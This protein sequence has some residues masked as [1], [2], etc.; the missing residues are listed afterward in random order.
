MSGFQI[1]RHLDAEH[2]ISSESRTERRRRRRRSRPIEGLIR[3]VR[4]R[5][6]CLGCAAGAGAAVGCGGLSSVVAIR[7]PVSRNSADLLFGLDGDYPEL[8]VAAQAHA[9][10]GRATEPARGRLDVEARRLRRL[11]TVVDCIT[12]MTEQGEQLLDV[13]DGIV[14]GRFNSDRI[15][16]ATEARHP[17]GFPNAS[18]NFVPVNQRQVIPAIGL[19]AAAL[20]TV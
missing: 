10:A 1:R 19:E 12:G 16:V 5:V 14:L 11:L 18:H 8:L 9:Q 20:A 17:V 4:G 6:R 2:L 7:L 3:W 13:P 15:S